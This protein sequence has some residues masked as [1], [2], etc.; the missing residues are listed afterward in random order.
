[1][2]KCNKSFEFYGEELLKIRK[3][4]GLSQ[5]ELANKIN[6]SRQSIHLWESGK[7]IPDIENIVSLC[8]ALEVTKTQLTNGLDFIESKEKNK[9]KINVKKIMKKIIL[10]CIIIFIVYFCDS[11]RKSIIL[12]SLNNKLVNYCG[13]NNY[14]YITSYFEADNKT[15]IPEYSYTNI[16]YYKDKVRK[17][18][19]ETSKEHSIL[20]ENYKDNQSYNFDENKAEYEEN[21]DFNLQIPENAFIPVGL[22]EK[23]SLGKNLQIV[24]FL[25]GFNPTFKIKTSKTEYTLYWSTKVLNSTEKIIEK[26]DKSTGLVKERQKYK[27]DKYSITTYEIKFNETTDKDIEIPNIDEYTKI[28][29]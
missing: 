5:E 27:K 15:L 24:N 14:S 26:I 29:Y 2:G 3:S 13:A 1:M 10:I 7:M 9:K 19:F 20:Y 4:K 12:M 25:Y 28:S 8:N 22:S 18:I 17:C 23:V 6:V 16:V 21:L 11:I